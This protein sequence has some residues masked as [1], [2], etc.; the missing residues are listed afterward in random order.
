[1]IV[2]HMEG[3]RGGEGRGGREARAR[4]GDRAP[5]EQQGVVRE[6]QGLSLGPV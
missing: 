2:F 4:T 1:M 6:C 5:P 3:G